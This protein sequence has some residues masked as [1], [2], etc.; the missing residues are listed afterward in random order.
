PCAWVYQMLGLPVDLYTP[1]FVA[2]R[3]SGWSAH[4][5]EQLDNNRLIRPRGLYVGPEPRHVPA[6]RA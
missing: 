5:I 3:V 6:D 2:S 1:I 4:I